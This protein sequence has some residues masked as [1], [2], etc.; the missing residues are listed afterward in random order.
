MIQL[1][2]EYIQSRYHTPFDDLNQKLDL[3]AARKHIK[4]LYDF[5]TEVA[6]TDLEIKWHESNPFSRENN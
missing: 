5:I 1:W 2:N 4:I 3:D 6:N